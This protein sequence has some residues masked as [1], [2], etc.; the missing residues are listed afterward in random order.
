[1]AHHFI[2]Y[3]NSRFRT[4]GSS[5]NFTYNI[6]LPKSI[7]YDQFD[8][9][10]MMQASIPKSFYLINTGRNTFVLTEGATS[11]TITLPVGNYTRRSL[12]YVVRSQ[13]NTQSPNALTYDISVPNVSTGPETGKYLFSVSNNVTNIP[14]YF[15]FPPT[16]SPAQ[17]LGFDPGSINVFV[18]NNLLSSN[19]ANLQI[20]QSLYVMCD[21]VINGY[22]HILQEI[23]TTS[24]DFSSLA[25]N[26]GFA[27]GIDANVKPLKSTL[28]NTWSFK[29]MTPD[30]ELIDFEGLDVVF[31]LLIWQSKE[32]QG[33]LPENELTPIPNPNPNPNPNMNLNSTQ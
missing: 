33:L 17:Q 8:S 16:S 22:S 10:C 29:F 23:F 5:S 28:T 6:D 11:V 14:L 26:V 24:P 31:S 25:F 18:L 13:L 3:V 1:M 19:V 15:S 30:F 7:G 27:G 32:P 2:V 9:V 12:A 4:S 21:N 20:T